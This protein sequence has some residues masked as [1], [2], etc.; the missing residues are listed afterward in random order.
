MKK[1]LHIIASPREDE[2]R[3]LQVSQPFLEIFQE[4][5]PEYIIDELDLSKEKLPDLSVMSVSG[6]YVL[7]EGKDVFGRL[8][9]T[10]NEIIQYIERFKSADLIL[11][12][13]PMWN[14][15]I[16][17]FL[18]HFIDLI[19]QPRYTFNYT[20]KGSE[21]LVNNTK[22]IIITS[23]G[24]RYGSEEGRLWDFQEPYLKAIFGLVGITDI[25]F[26]KAEGMDLT[27]PA[28][29]QR[30]EDAIAEAKELAGNIE[31]ASE[32]S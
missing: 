32:G 20:K 5:H 14:Y 15:S 31:F 28:K 21:G 7:L 18:K 1:L 27:D 17:Y 23:R 3:T 16:P 22:M 11:I 2:S 24:G 30:L 13:T 12:S 19:V 25:T 4:K 10:W 29:K 26:I 6:K 9:E 8:R